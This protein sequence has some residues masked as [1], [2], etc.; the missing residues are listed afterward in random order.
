MPWSII[1]LGAIFVPTWAALLEMRY[2]WGL[3]HALDNG[4]LLRLI[5]AEPHTALPIAAHQAL[6][7]LNM[8]HPKCDSGVPHPTHNTAKA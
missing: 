5:D 6:V 3:P 2:L 4:K 1:R 8:I 7:D